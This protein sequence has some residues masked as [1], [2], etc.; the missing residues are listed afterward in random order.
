MT[1]IWLLLVLFG[2]ALAHAGEPASLV[3]RGGTVYTVDAARSWAEAIAVDGNRIVYVGD[4]DGAAAFIGPDTQV[5]E[6]DGRMVLPGFQDSHIHPITA[7]LKS[8]MCNLAGLGSV[9]EYLEKVEECVAEHGDAEWIHGTG[10]SHEFFP[11]DDKPTARMLDEVA[12]HVPLTLNSYDGHS[13]WAN[14]KAMQVAGVDETTPDPES[15]GIIRYPGSMRPTGLF[16]EDQAQTLVLQAKPPYAADVVYDGL[17]R[18]QEYLNSLGI[19]SVQDAIVD[20]AEGGQYSVL[21]TYRQAAERG[22]LTLRVVGAL[23]W[24]PSKG[25]EQVE[26][27]QRARAEYSGGLFRATSVKIWYDGVMHTRTSKLIEPYADREGEYGM[28]LVS[29]ERLNELSVAL[30]SKGFQLHFHA[31]GDAAVHECLDAVEAALEANGRSDNR[32]HIAH[33]ELVDPADLPRF[34]QLGVIANVQPMWSTYPPYIED[35]IENKIGKERSRWLE[36]NRSFLEHGVTVAYGSDWFV[37]SPRPVDLIEAAVTRIRPSFPQEIKRDA[38]PP[39]PGE[40]VSVADAIA[41]Y[42]INGA[43]LNHQETETGSIEVGKLADLVVLSD[44]LFDVEPV[45]ISETEVLLTVFD[46][47]VVHDALSDHH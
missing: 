44:N 9:A 34:R 30:D 2:P 20:I 11:D 1:R 24:E 4:N 31:D 35:L 33:L 38:I 10:W 39:L 8:Y 40:E 5:Y 42:T 28:S 7:S 23:Y 25:M 45:R 17:L 21:P 15:G 22:E 29:P 16:L 27:I 19:T 18:V 26:D 14:S 3:L 37:T 43:Y 13:L 41:S 36:I 46:G 32:H 47:R 6:L 12:P